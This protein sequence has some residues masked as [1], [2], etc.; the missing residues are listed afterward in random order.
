METIKVTQK[1]PDWITGGTQSKG[2]FKVR[3]DV[4]KEKQA[5]ERIQKAINLTAYAMSEYGCVLV[6]DKLLKK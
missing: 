1:Y 2:S 4:S 5:R 6:N 3:V